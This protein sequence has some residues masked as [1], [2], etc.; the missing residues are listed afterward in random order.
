V[1]ASTGT[2][3]ASVVA[4]IRRR[5]ANMGSTS[6]RVVKSSRYALNAASAPTVPTVHLMP[7]HGFASE[8][9]IGRGIF[10]SHTQKPQVRTRQTVRTTDDRC[11]VMAWRMPPASQPRDTRSREVDA[12]SARITRRHRQSRAD[13]G[14]RRPTS[15][16][17]QR[18][19]GQPRKTIAASAGKR[20]DR[21]SRPA[22]RTCRALRRA[23]RR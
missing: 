16:R 15:A 19:I 13:V 11:G 23:P 2:A 17:S 1:D 8:P 10:R 6:Q 12:A 18:T 21:R 9:P 5:D 14:P 3:K 7:V 4:Q 20:P 22:P